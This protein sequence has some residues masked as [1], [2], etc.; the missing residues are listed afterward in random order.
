MSYAVRNDGMGWRAVNSA[1]D[2]AVDETYSNAQ[3]VLVVTLA[4]ARVSANAAIDAQAEQ[5]RAKYCSHPLLAMEYKRAYDDAVA[6][7]TNQTAPVPQSLQAWINANV[8][9]SWTALQSANNIKASGDFM[10]GKLDA[11]R[12][13]RL[14]GKAAVMAALTVTDAQ[15]AQQAAITALS[16]L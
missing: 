4:Q 7:L 16:A 15:A 13:A 3:P 14:M 12:N 9:N 2:C 5:M 1:A 6:W 11:M 8:V 10:N